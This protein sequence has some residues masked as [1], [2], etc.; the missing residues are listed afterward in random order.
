[1]YD[2]IAAVVP[3][4]VMSIADILRL[5]FLVF[6]GVVILVTMVMISP[7]FVFNP[8]LRS[9]GLSDAYMP[10]VL[11][12]HLFTVLLL[13]IAGIKVRR[14]S[15]VGVQGS[16]LYMYNHTSYI[17]AVVILCALR[18]NAYFV[19]KREL[20]YIPLI[21]WMLHLYGHIPISR[22]D[23]AHAIETLRQIGGEL[24]ARKKCIAIAPEGTRSSTGQ[25]GDFKKG[26]FHLALSCPNVPVVPVYI[27]NANRVMP[28]GSVFLQ[29]GI[30]DVFFC[31][32]I[33][34]YKI[35]K[36]VAMPCHKKNIYMQQPTDQSL[37]VARLQNQVR[38][39]LE[40]QSLSCYETIDGKSK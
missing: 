10:S 16:K 19:F 37:C 23:R 31:D 30:I 6:F 13:S 29:S 7:L 3:R 11:I 34:S 9:I 8:V 2:R 39:S 18:G 35:M 12:T 40:Q 33:K 25:L 27:H 22:K 24:N 28:R 1:M 4:L 38:S 20:G 14:H 32:P 15:S 26:P 36:D 21:G 5:L 17:D